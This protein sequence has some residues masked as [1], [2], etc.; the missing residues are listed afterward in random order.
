MPEQERIKPTEK[1][2]KARRNRSIA[3]ALALAAFVIIVYLG[4]LMK[5]G[6]AVF[7]RAM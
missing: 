5:L 2:L 6:P 3:I 1:Q 4:S 7:D